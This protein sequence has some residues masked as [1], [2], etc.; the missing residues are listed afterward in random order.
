MTTTCPHCGT[1]T[2]KGWRAFYEYWARL[3][4]EGYRLARDRGFDPREYVHHGDKT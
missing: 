2:C 4:G 3:S 1:Q